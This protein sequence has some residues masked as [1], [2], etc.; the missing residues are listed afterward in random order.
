VA[1]TAGNGDPHAARVNFT[2]TNFV[3]TI[4]TVASTGADI[5][6]VNAIFRVTGKN[7]PVELMQFE[8]D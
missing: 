4:A 5:P 1:L 3:P 2:S 8:V 6:N 7:L